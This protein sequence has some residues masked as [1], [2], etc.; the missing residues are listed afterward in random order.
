MFILCSYI[1]TLLVTNYWRCSMYIY[2]HTSTVYSVNSGK[3]PWDSD[4][5]N[6]PSMPHLRNDDSFMK[7][8]FIHPKNHD[9]TQFI[10]ILH[11]RSVFGAEGLA[12][13]L[14]FSFTIL[15]PWQRPVFGTRV[16]SPTKRLIMRPTG[17]L[18]LAKNPAGQR[19]KGPLMKESRMQA[20]R[21]WLYVSAFSCRNA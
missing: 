1:T 14:S 3:P 5:S 13:F 11:P 18:S 12:S 21:L 8:V 2:E 15:H 10:L 20:V 16:K 4:L 9:F 19:F 7:Y 6:D 17:C